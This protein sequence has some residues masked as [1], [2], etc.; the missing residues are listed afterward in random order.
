MKGLIHCFSVIS[1]II[2]SCFGWWNWHQLAIAGNIH[3]QPLRITA[4]ATQLPDREA[5][6]REDETACVEFGQKIDLN[7]ANIIA[8]KDCQG[9]YPTLAKL[10]VTNGPYQTVEDVVKIP[11]LSDRQKELLTTYFDR[12]T[13]TESVVP[14]VMRMPPRPAIRK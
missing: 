4:I 14:L 1:I 8:F 2:V 7:N 5:A 10:I 9:F 12:F 13:V 3:V 6:D 11:G